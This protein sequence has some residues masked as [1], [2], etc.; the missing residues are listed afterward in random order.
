MCCW[1][2]LR[3]IA[4]RNDPRRSLRITKTESIAVESVYYWHYSLSDHLQI[5]R[6]ITKFV[7]HY[8]FVGMEDAIEGLR[9]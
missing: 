4:P 8:S 1:N 3:C 7:H 9:D 6:C 2:F 5:Q